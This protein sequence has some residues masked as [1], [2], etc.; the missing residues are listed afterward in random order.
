MERALIVASFGSGAPG[1]GFVRV[2]TSPAVR[3]ILAGR[4]ER[5][6][7]LTEALESLRSAGTRRV[8]I[9][10]THL[11]CGVE[12]E[13]LKAESESF[14]GDFETLDLGRPLLSDADDVRRF[15]S[16]LSAAHPAREGAVTVFLGH[17]AERL[18]GA[19]YPALQT[20]LRLEGWEDLLVGSVKGWPTLDDVLRQLEPG[21]PRRIELVPMMLTAGRHARQD[22]AG[23]WKSRLER[24]GHLVT[25][26]F[27][28][29]GERGWVQKMY[30]E[31]LDTFLKKYEM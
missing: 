22:M 21:G 27:I 4:G 12:Y 17:G 28:G 13:R 25:C 16:R 1:Y 9:Q 5:V 3:R 20:G 10:P 8:L 24:A 19:V 31:R 6:L 14:S 18:A 29:L 23:E 7:S 11:L 26:S 2:F 30:R 15:A